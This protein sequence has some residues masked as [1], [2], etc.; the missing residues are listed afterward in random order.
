[1]RWKTNTVGRYTDISRSSE[2]RA[3]QVA[4]LAKI[5][6]EK[7]PKLEVF[8]GWTSRV[9]DDKFTCELEDDLWH[10]LNPS[11]TTGPMAGTS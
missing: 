8:G 10:I 2:S 1:V 3:Q 5:I 11:G 9:E 7:Y 4:A 6:R